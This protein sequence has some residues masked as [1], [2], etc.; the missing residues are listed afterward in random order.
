MRDLRLELRG[1]LGSIVLCNLDFGFKVKL[2]LGCASDLLGAGRES[3][4]Q[5]VLGGLLDWL[6]TDGGQSIDLSA[7]PVIWF[8]GFV[9]SRFGA[10]LR[11]IFALILIFLV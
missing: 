7:L 6:F 4:W 9:L 2:R 3:W 1:Y 8:L 5:F 10:L 11:C